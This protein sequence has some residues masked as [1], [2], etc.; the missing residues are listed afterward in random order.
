MFSI[1]KMYVA[2]LFLGMGLG[3]I[4]TALPAPA[5]IL[6]PYLTIIFFIIGII[7]LVLRFFQFVRFILFDH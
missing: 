4:I 5:D 7:F 1:D 2:M 6:N 3:G